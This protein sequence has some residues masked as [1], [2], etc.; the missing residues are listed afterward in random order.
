MR[1]IK[2]KNEVVQ[3]ADSRGESSSSMRL[4]IQTVSRLSNNTG[5]I[6]RE[7]STNYLD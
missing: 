5:M 4:P 6:I 1:I 2:Y 3:M 7:R